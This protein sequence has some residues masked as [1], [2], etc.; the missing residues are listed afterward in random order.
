MHYTPT[1]GSWLNMVEIELSA[2]SRQCLSRRIPD[3][4]TLTSEVRACVNQR[5]E[6]RIKV[7]WQFTVNK[8]RD[9]FQRFY[10]NPS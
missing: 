9:K 4:S 10:Y 5:N 6:K 3:I 1:N 8:A 7:D 2:I